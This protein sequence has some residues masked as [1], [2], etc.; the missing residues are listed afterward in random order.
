MLTRFL[1]WI[2]TKVAGKELDRLM[3]TNPDVKKGKKLI[4][5]GA[6]VLRKDLERKYGKEYA[7]KAFGIS[8][9]K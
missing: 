3:K 4:N 7:D 6:E 9:D 2:L 5:E 1:T 8:K